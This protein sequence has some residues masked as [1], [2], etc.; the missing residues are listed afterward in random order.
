MRERLSEALRVRLYPRQ[1]NKLAVLAERTS[2]SESEAVRFL[3]DH[4]EIQEVKNVGPVAKF[5][6]H[7]SG[8]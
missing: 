7:T 2:M 6:V 3:I 5:A 4:A 1:A 8:E